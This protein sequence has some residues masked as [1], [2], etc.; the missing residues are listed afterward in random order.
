MHVLIFICLLNSA[1]F[2][3]RIQVD[4]GFYSF[5]KE[6]LLRSHSYLQKKPG[7]VAACE[8]MVTLIHTLTPGSCPVLS[9]HYTAAP[10]NN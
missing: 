1:R 3:S 6:R 7:G 5:N 8:E 9:Q 2:F 10:P 4:G